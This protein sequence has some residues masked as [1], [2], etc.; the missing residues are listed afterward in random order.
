MTD[1]N[2]FIESPRL[3]LC[4]FQPD[5]DAHCD[6]LVQLYNTP[7]FIAS[8]GGH[9]TSITTRAAAR[10]QLEGRFRAEHARNGYGTYLILLKPEAAGD[11]GEPRGPVVVRFAPRDDDDAPCLAVGTVSLMR[12]EPPDGYAA[13]DLGFAVLPPYMRRGVATE[14][15]RALLAF[16]ERERGVKAVLGLL[17]PA[18]AASRAV[19]ARL[20]FQDR[21]MRELRAFGGVRGAVYALPSMSEDLAVYG[22]PTEEAYA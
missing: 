17:D 16:A 11:D 7:E 5:D 15:S 20:G 10:A 22:L 14:A 4:Y 2:F 8:I 18:N 9:P 19:F 13:P 6:F 12:G 21:G 1:P 3:F